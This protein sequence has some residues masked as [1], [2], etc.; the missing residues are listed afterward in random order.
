MSTKRMSRKPHSQR[1]QNHIQPRRERAFEITVINNNRSIKRE[2]PN[3]AQ[4]MAKETKEMNA[5]LYEMKKQTMELEKQVKIT[6]HAFIISILALI[7]SI[8]SVLVPIAYEYFMKDRILPPSISFMISSAFADENDNLSIRDDTNDIMRTEFTIFEANGKMDCFA[9]NKHV[10]YITNNNPIAIGISDI[11]FRVKEYYP[12]TDFFTL[13]WIEGWGDRQ[14]N[15]YTFNIG[16]NAPQI[17]HGTKCD[18]NRRPLNDTF[19]R[20]AAGDIESFAIDYNFTTPGVYYGELVFVVE[21][22]NEQREQVVTN[23]S[24]EASLSKIVYLPEAMECTEVT[25]PKFLEFDPNEDGKAYSADGFTYIN[26][27]FSNIDH[28]KQHL[29]NYYS[30]AGQY[31]QYVLDYYVPF[32][33]NTYYGWDIVTNSPV[34]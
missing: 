29:Q 12:I 15:V 11:Y 26:D 6:R 27:T 2:R 30:K 13:Y 18:S 5:E 10:F 7:I 9:G 25:S 21:I 1:I 28:I 17:Y 22:N 32:F 33:K 24:S 16:T 34:E 20:I 14:H 4:N 31:Y 23:H 19:T 3:E 8:L